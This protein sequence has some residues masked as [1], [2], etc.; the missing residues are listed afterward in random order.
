ML[1]ASLLDELM[2]STD[3]FGGG[4][5][6]RKMQELKAWQMSRKQKQQKQ[7]TANPVTVAASRKSRKSLVL[8]Y[9]IGKSKNGSIRFANA[10]LP[11]VSLFM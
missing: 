8:G 11:V 7:A 5:E 10:E 1:T 9:S 4:N 6:E 3:C 2:C